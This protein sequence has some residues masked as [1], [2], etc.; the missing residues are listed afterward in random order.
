MIRKKP[1]AYA[2]SVAVAASSL[3]VVAQEPQPGEVEVDENLIVTGTRL[4]MNAFSSPTP[5]DVIDTGDALLQGVNDVGRLLQ[6]STLAAG[7][8]QVTPSLS[9]E[10]VMD[11]G[12]GVQTL[13]LRGLGA[14]RTLVL[15]NGRRAGPAGTRGSISSFDLNVI[16]LSVIER[17]EILKDGA[18]SIYGS[19]AIAGVVNIITRKTEGVTVDGYYSAPDETGGQESR[20]N[21]TWG[22]VG[23]RGSFQIA[24]DFYEQSELA[25]GDRDYLNCGEYYIFDPDTGQRADPIDPRTGQPNCIDLLWGQIWLYDY[26][27]PATGNVPQPIGQSGTKAQFDYDGTLA[28]VAQPFAVDPSNPEYLTAPPGWFPVWGARERDGYANAD[29]PFQ[30]Q[31]SLIPKTERVTVFMEGDRSFSERLEGYME[32]LL[33]RRKTY[34]NSYRQFWSYLWNS[35]GGGFLPSNTSPVVAGWTGAQWLSPTPITDHADD[36]IEI[37]YQRFVAGLRGDINA[38]WSW[39]VSYQHS[40]S[41]GDYDS[42]IIYDDSIWDQN[43]LYGPCE[44]TPTS[45]RGVPC[46]DVPWLDPDFNNGIVSQEVRDFLFGV[47]HGNTV[48]EQDSLEGYVSGLFGNMRGGPLGIAAGVHLQDDSIRDVPG[49][50]SQ[51]GNVWGSSSAGITE[52]DDTTT[53]VF[54]EL[55]LPVTNAFTITGSTRYTDV[56]SYGSDTTYKVGLNWQITDSWRVRANTGTSFRTPSLFELYLNDQTGFL[57]QRAIDPC[58]DW[59]TASDAG[60]IPPRVAQNC[61]ADGIPNDFTGGGISATIISGGGLGR[62]KAETSDSDTIGVIW[63]PAEKNLSI[64]VDYYEI[65]VENE[66]DQLGADQIVYGCYNSDFFPSDPLCDLFDRSGVGMGID[67]V[68][69]SYIN[70]ATQKNKGVDWALNWQTMQRWG[71]LTLDWQLSVQ[72]EDIKALFADT[73]T[74]YNGE[75]GEP[76]RVGQLN[77]VLERGNWTYY[78][79]Y[80]YIGSSSSYDSFGGNTSTYRGETVNVILHTDPIQYHTFSFTREF[81]AQQTTVRFGVANAFDENPPKVTT[82]SLGEID[83]VGT[84]PFYSQYDWFG[85]RVFAN[86]TKTWGSGNN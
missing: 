69:D 10:F 26:Q 24:A 65:L 2:V 40:E 25:R 84:S 6:T 29:H 44:G 56:D 12:I 18:S 46:V 34:F 42:D 63:Q 33:N 62:L 21:F 45:V 13:S 53:A 59:E 48:Y 14:Q 79:G 68:M 67:N 39:D 72:N 27:D 38:D 31:S 58:I 50:S 80:D 77:V 43:W 36:A 55:E 83:T 64:A 15:M 17:V 41:D 7:S 35:D 49:E 8:A 73:V 1:L 81:P 82:M 11:G 9:G 54:A 75:I 16:P 28:T 30:D 4:R 74:D 22:E 51:I 20:F 23:E 3:A 85:R 60:E 61:A 19:D 78:W 52:G 70:I 86:F 76:K 5:M 71:T 57:D 66:V 32:V 37:D 47:D